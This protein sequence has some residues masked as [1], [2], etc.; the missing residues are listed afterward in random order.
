M[1]FA[2]IDIGSEQHVIA[3]VD[4]DGTV[5][6]KPTKFAEDADGYARVLA[7]LGAPSGLLVAME[8]TGHYWQNLFAVLAGHGYTLALLNPVRTARFAGEE[9]ARTKTDA[10]DAVGIARF[11]QQKRPAATPL[12]DETTRSLRELVLLRE[13]L[14]QEVGDK[15]RQLHRAVDLCFPEFTRHVKTLD[16]ELALTV[17]HAL[18]TAATYAQVTPAWLARQVY[19]GRHKVDRDLAKA[20]CTAAS[21][22]VGQHRGPVYELE[23]RYLCA[24]IRLLKEQLQ[25]LEGDIERTLVDSEVGTLLTTITGIGAQTS[26]RIIAAV[27]DPARFRDAAAFAACLGVVPGLKH[28]GKHTPARAALSPFGHARLRRALWMPA[29]V[30]VRRNPWLRAFYERLVANASGARSRSSPRS[31]NSPTPSTAWPSTA[32]PSCRASAPPVRLH[33]ETA[34]WRRRYLRTWEAFASRF[35]FDRSAPS[36]TTVPISS[37][38]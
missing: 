4:D 19:D 14:V 21:V 23:V 8:A 10:I 37:G 28:S 3:V 1:R 25:R 27:G 31:A 2:G 24:Q 36:R 35:S 18:P 38:T 32:A 34:C 11:A 7:V 29:L 6:T 13:R 22:S 17:L 5:T 20:L 12:A 15:V 30:A 9:M 26:A 16:S 33:D